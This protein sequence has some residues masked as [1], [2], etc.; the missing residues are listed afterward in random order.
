MALGLG[1][2]AVAA[3]WLG[4]ASI[5]T[6]SPGLRANGSGAPAAEGALR[7]EDPASSLGGS[8]SENGLRPSRDASTRGV[9][10]GA[11]SAPGDARLVLSGGAFARL[12]PSG[13]FE[14]QQEPPFRILGVAAPGWE[15]AHPQ[16]SWVVVARATEGLRLPWRALARRARASATALTENATAP[17]GGERRDETGSAE[18]GSN[19]SGYDEA[20]HQVLIRLDT[21]SKAWSTHIGLARMVKRREVWEGER[22]VVGP[23]EVVRFRGL[24]PGRYRVMLLRDDLATATHVLVVTP[25][26]PASSEPVI[27][28]ESASILTGRVTDGEGRAIT[29]ATLETSEVLE[30]GWDWSLAPPLSV[31]PVRPNGAFR[32]KIPRGQYE[33]SAFAPDYDGARVVVGAPR[34]SGRTD[35]AMEL[36]PLTLRLER[37]RSTSSDPENEAG[38]GLVLKPR[39]Y[40]MR[41][42]STRAGSGAE[43]AGLKPG[44]WIT[45]V[46]GQPIR[47]IGHHRAI[48]RLLGEAGTTVELEVVP[49]GAQGPARIRV[50]RRAG[51]RDRLR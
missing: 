26:E 23:V 6:Q 24:E 14:I 28:W 7:N 43:E 27:R 5:G 22:L 41:V 8:E 19:G 13:R 51:M 37:T 33:V 15:P 32:V 3:V 49:V 9:V 35:A 50:E 46:S 44:D 31:R 40:E 1:V 36:R 4:S 18:A 25:G 42:V 16:R 34:E 29:E 12:D 38:L 47:E 21:E 17:R 45:R 11:K 48:E 10:V 39:V 20:E 2:T 30:R